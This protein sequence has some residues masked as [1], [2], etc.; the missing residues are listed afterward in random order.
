MREAARASA[1]LSSALV[2]AS[3]ARPWVESAPS[4]VT[5][6]RSAS[7][8]VAR[9]TAAHSGEVRRGRRHA[10]RASSDAS[11]AATC[12]SAPA[13]SSSSSARRAS[14]VMRAIEVARERVD[15]R[16]GVVATGHEHRGARHEQPGLGQQR[17]ALSGGPYAPGVVR[18]GGAPRLVDLAVGAEQPCGVGSLDDERG[19]LL[20]EVEQQR[21]AR[22]GRARR[23]RRC[24]A[25]TEVRVDHSSSRSSTRRTNANA[26]WPA[27][28]STRSAARSVDSTAG[29]SGCEVAH[30]HARAQGERHLARHDDR[31][32]RDRL[33]QVMG[34]QPLDRR[35]CA[36]PASTARSAPSTRPTGG[37]HTRRSSASRAP[38]GASAST[39]RTVA[40]SSA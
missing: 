4:P 17:P 13:A 12:R 38:S 35:A 16:A 23:G 8:G 19:A 40:G 14:G 37:P 30:E 7:S 3:S 28:R 33:E 36:A 25:P 6:M 21:G 10:S 32:G 5:P 15:P 22:R 1:E 34:Q 11:A 2:D 20:V 29:G 9:T 24:A 26:C 31:V 18:R 27:V 39:A